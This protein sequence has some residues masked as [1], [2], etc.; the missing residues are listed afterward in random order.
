M[1]KLAHVLKKITKVAVEKQLDLARNESIRSEKLKAIEKNRLKE[2][3]DR[4]RQKELAKSIALKEEK[5][6]IANIRNI[7]KDLI[8]ANWDGKSHIIL[9]NSYQ[10]YHK[11]FQ[12]YNLEVFNHRQICLVLNKGF[13]QLSNQIFKTSNLANELGY[14]GLYFDLNHL[15]DNYVNKVRTNSNSVFLKNE[16]KNAQEIVIENLKIIQNFTLKIKAENKKLGDILNTEKKEHKKFHH[17]N[18]ARLS[19]I[20]FLRLLPT[21]RNNLY[22]INSEYQIK[23]AQNPDINE[24]AKGFLLKK[25]INTALPNEDLINFNSL[26][27][28][29]LIRKAKYLDPIETLDTDDDVKLVATK[30]NSL[31]LKLEI[32]D[33]NRKVNHLKEMNSQLKKL[34]VELEKCNIFSNENKKLINKYKNTIDSFE[35]EFRNKSFV[36]K[37]LIKIKF[38]SG[39]NDERLLIYLNAIKWLRT[40]E[41]KL[42]KLNLIT[43]LTNIAKKSV[44]FVEIKLVENENQIN[45]KINQKLLSCTM[46]TEILI[47][48]FKFLG[49]G[50]KKISD[51]GSNL[52]YQLNW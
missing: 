13:K 5:K 12:K 37:D 27:V 28:I 22:Y 8:F 14:S 49:L 19:E 32:N 46:P 3:E 26:D 1:P 38:K 6:L 21:I 30:K 4:K 7:L 45:F 51:N 34:I 48:L 47:G 36:S 17:T 9:K 18:G 31:T 25:I 20:D 15:I 29:N 52:T 41:G 39:L 50:T 16:Q 42:F 24:L 11:D 10:K 43:S 35:I 2:I 44:N 23:L 40:K 33:L